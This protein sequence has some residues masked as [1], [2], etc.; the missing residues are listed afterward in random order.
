[1]LLANTNAGGS[2]CRV[3]HTHTSGKVY[4]S[5]GYWAEAHASISPSGTRIVFGS[6]WE[7]SGSVDAYVIEL[8]GYTP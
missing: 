6:D 4:S 2:V 1:M 3:A 5:L 7:N 8:P